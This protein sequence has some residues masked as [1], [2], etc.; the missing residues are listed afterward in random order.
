MNV[1]DKFRLV[2]PSNLAYGEKGAGDV[3]PPIQPLY[4]MLS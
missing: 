1:G 4:L 2:I 3:I